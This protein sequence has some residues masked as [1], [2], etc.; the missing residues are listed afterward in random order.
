MHISEG[1]L[2]APV[3]ISG[4]AIT[5]AG[6]GLGLKRINYEHIP[7]V[8][9][10][11]SAFFVAS[12]IHIPLGPANV[13]LLMIGIVGIILGWASFPAL[14]VSLFIQTILFQFGGFTTLGINTL[15]MALPAIMCFYM[16]SRLIRGKNNSLAIIGGFF[17]GFTAV[18]FAAFLVALSLTLTGDSFTVVARLIILV[19]IPVMIIEGI[20]TGFIIGF[21]RKTKPEILGGYT[22]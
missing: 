5:A 2:T 19:H 3:L 11:S 20:I 7:K 8:A 13:H 14:L 4:A 10:L 15:N 21:L 1:V 22:A 6:C 9:V 18:L 16:F 12:L 17:A